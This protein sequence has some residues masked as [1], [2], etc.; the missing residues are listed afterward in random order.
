[1]SMKLLHLIIGQSVLISCEFSYGHTSWS[2]KLYSHPSCKLCQSVP[3][4]PEDPPPPTNP[5][6]WS[7]VQETRCLGELMN[8]MPSNLKTKFRNNL[9]LGDVVSVVRANFVHNLYLFQG[10]SRCTLVSCWLLVC[11]LLLQWICRRL[12]GQSLL[13]LPPL[14]SIPTRIHF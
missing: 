5:S 6:S 14:L 9:L 8:R 4:H 11:P 12:L 13:L 7:T 10:V 2:V 1:M 3:K